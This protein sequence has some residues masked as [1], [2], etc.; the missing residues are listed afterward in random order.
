MLGLPVLAYIAFNVDILVASKLVSAD[1]IGFYGMS[2][3]LARTPL[4]L[5]TQIISPILLPV[6]SEKQD[7]KEALCRAIL[8]ITQSVMLFTVPP[9][10]LAVICSKMILSL[11][12]GT[13]YSMVAV[14]F[15]L[16]C[17]YVLLLMQGNIL[18]RVFFGI[19]QPGKHRAFVGL[20]VLLLVILIYPAVRL[21]GVTGAAA[22]L[23]LASF[24]ALFVQ[25][26][27]IRRVIGLSIIE[28]V[29]SWLPGLVLA[30]PTLIIV[31]FVRILK[32]D[33][34]V[35]HLAIG[36]SSCSIVYLTILFWHLFRRQFEK[37]G[38]DDTIVAECLEH[39]KPKNA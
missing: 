26:L 5:F 33:F 19:G 31:I 18:A 13:E 32:P 6:F 14:P 15:S 1:L 21:F 8:K 17:I 25:V 28:Y 9:M 30:I 20:R 22:T 12:Y 37:H 29:T 27:I 11:V 3:L 2:L 10:V 35:L 36:I 4:D 39:G 16:L 7:D 38:L 34:Q 23:L 24:I